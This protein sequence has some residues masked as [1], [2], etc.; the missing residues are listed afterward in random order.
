MPG[1]DHNQP[2][3]YDRLPR[4]REEPIVHARQMG[5]EDVHIFKSGPA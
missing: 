3:R 4:G 1:A 2:V 5:E